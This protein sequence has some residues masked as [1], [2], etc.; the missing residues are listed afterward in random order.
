V[1]DANVRDRDLHEVK[2]AQF[3]AANCGESL[4]HG[5]VQSRG[6][7]LDGVPNAVH[8]L[9]RDAARSDRHELQDGTNPCAVTF[10][11]YL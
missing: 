11:D 9:N 4:C 10:K 5:M 8:V 6:R 3:L 7:N 1:L 2:P